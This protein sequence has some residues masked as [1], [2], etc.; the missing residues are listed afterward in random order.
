MRQ[1]KHFITKDKWKRNNIADGIGVYNLPE[2]VVSSNEF[3]FFGM[4]KNYDPS[5]DASTDLKSNVSNIAY[6]D[7][8]GPDKI[9]PNRRKK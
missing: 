4:P 9:S 2:E 5:M 1:L 6:D 8:A 7:K 3:K